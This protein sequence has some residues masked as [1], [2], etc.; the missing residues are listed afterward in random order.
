MELNIERTPIRLVER[1]TFYCRLHCTLLT[2]ITQAER[3]RRIRATNLCA[4]TRLLE[5]KEQSN[6]CQYGA[7]QLVDWVP[8]YGLHGST[9]SDAGSIATSTPSWHPYR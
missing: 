7:T 3:I 2:N 5:P 9:F 4:A 6:T 8:L 1:L